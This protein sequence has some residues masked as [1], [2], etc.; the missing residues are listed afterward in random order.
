MKCW[1]WDVNRGV[2]SCFVRAFFSS[3]SG[4]FNYTGPSCIS[5]WVCL[6]MQLYA[7]T[8]LYGFSV[9]PLN[10]VLHLV[11]GV[12]TWEGGERVDSGAARAR[13]CPHEAGDAAQDRNGM[14]RQRRVHQQVGHQVPGLVYNWQI[15]AIARHSTLSCTHIT[16]SSDMM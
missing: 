6:K 10:R 9:S 12:K 14:G 4:I 16:P 15:Y 7:H 1:C 8:H 3:S 5:L 11:T 13:K 2:L